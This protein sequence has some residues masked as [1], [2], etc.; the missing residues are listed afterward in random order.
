MSKIKHLK[1]IEEYISNLTDKDF[2]SFCDRLLSRLFPNAVQ[3]CSILENG[4]N[5]ISNIFFVVVPNEFDESV[6][7]ESLIPDDIEQL[8]PTAITF[9]S[10]DSFSVTPEQ[11]KKIRKRTGVIRIDI[12]GLETLKLK[13]SFFEQ[14]EQYFIIDDDSIF[15]Q[16]LT[17][18]PDLTEE[19]DIIDNIFNF[20]KIQSK[21]I[22]SIP[23]EKSE[24]YNGIVKKIKYNFDAYQ[25]RVFDMYQLTYYHKSLVENYFRDTSVSDKTEVITLREFFR[26]KYCEISN[27]PKSTYP[28]NDFKFLEMLADSCLEDK[29]KQN[30]KYKLWAKA[31]V[32]YFF[33]YCDFGARNKQDT[34]VPKK[35]GL[36]DNYNA[37]LN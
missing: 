13:L 16:F 30:V 24:K 19:M 18:E 28:V 34:M 5:V 27:Y 35:P 7:P 21:P 29:F 12:W 9:L 32:M 17:S 31:I 4:Y 8:A 26:S 33:E 37:D 10:K 3:S 20:I 23:D 14:E 25:S 2:I 22:T 15:T 36:F 1:I 11:K 6:T